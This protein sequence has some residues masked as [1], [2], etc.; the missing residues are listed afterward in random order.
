MP[1][2]MLH[3]DGSEHAWFQDERRA[4]LITLM[5]DANNEVYYGQIVEQESTRTRWQ[6]CGKSSRARGCFAASIAIE[7]VIF[8]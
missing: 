7:P 4:D 1:G 3:I 6:D 8:L 5:D 2:M